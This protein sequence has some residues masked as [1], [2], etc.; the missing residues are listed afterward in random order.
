M[1]NENDEND[2]NNSNNNIKYDYVVSDNVEDDIELKPNVGKLYI[3]LKNMYLFSLSDNNIIN[4]FNV[5]EYLMKYPY[6]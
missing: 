1:N 6:K 4:S 2:R 5:Q 3:Y